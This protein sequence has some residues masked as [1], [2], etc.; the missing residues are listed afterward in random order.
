MT[1]NLR[2]NRKVSKMLIHAIPKDHEKTNLHHI[3]WNFQNHTNKIF[4]LE[5]L[6]LFKSK[7]FLLQRL[8]NG[9]YRLIV[10]SGTG[11]LCSFYIIDDI[12]RFI[13]IIG[14]KVVSEDGDPSLLAALEETKMVPHTGL[15]YIEGETIYVY[16]HTNY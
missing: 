1:P 14:I 5:K 6:G 8:E 9:Q 2:F 15:I 3:E 16:D 7:L 4:G 10:P 11:P 13:D 12:E